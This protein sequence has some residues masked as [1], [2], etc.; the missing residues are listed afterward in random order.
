MAEPKTP[1]VPLGTKVKART[2]GWDDIQADSYEASYEEGLDILPAGDG[3]PEWV[4]GELEGFLVEDSMKPYFKHI[5]DGYDVDPDTIEELTGSASIVADSS[6]PRTDN[7]RFMDIDRDLRTKLHVAFNDHMGRALERAGAKIRTRMSKTASGRQWLNEHPANNGVLVRIAPVSMVAA[8]GLEES[9]LFEA[10]WEELRPV[11]FD[12]VASGDIS[13]L[14][15]IGKV[16]GIDINTLSAQETALAAASEEGWE[17][18]RNRLDILAKGY[19]GDSA[20]VVAIDEITA[21]NLVDMGEVRQGVAIAGG[22]GMQDSTSAGLMVGD[23][24]SIGVQPQLSTGPIAQ[25]TMKGGGLEVQ[26]YTWV[27]GF[28]PSPFQPHLALDGVEFNSFI[29]PRLANRDTWPSN[30]YFMP[31]DHAGCQCDFYVNWRRS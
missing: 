25:D 10:A 4:E 20:T 2:A 28:T 19:M 30:D 7:Q 6:I 29:D 13:L 8:S 24:L 3:V 12:F 31:G 5:V 18:V 23:D 26:S 1:V 21:A 22:A 9:M 17:H 27:H 14:R 15:Q 16:T 11:W